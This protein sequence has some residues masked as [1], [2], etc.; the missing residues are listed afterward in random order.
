MMQFEIFII[1]LSTS[2]FI[3]RQGEYGYLSNKL[4]VRMKWNNIYEMPSSD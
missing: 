4:D 1:N 2:F 3:I